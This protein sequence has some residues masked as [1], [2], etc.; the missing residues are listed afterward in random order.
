MQDKLTVVPVFKG[1]RR[2]QFENRE[3]IEFSICMYQSL[4]YLLVILI[5]L[6]L[7]VTKAGWIYIQM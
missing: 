1:S 6:K 7:E 3:M 5:I 4:I 2:S